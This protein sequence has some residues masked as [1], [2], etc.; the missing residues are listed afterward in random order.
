MQG[1]LGFQPR[2][3]EA[4]A[5]KENPESQVAEGTTEM[6]PQ[7]RSKTSRVVLGAGGRML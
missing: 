1:F 4:A 7:E 3:L 2:W 5:E 6:W